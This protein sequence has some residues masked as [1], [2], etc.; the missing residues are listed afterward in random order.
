VTD[1]YPKI[2][3]GIPTK[4]DIDGIE[5]TV[6]SLDKQTI[7]PDRLIIC[8]GSDDATF[9]KLTDLLVDVNLSCDIVKQS[10]DGVASAYNQMLGMV[11]GDYEVFATLQTNLVVQNDWLENH[12]ECHRKMPDIG[13]VVP[14]DVESNRV[15]EAGAKGY[16]TMRNVSIKKDLLESVQ[17][18]DEN[19]LR[20]EDWDFHI[21]MGCDEATTVVS[22]NVTHSWRGN[23]SDVDPAVTLSKFTRRPTSITFI[24]KYGLWYLKFHPGHVIHDVLASVYGLCLFLGLSGYFLSPI[25]ASPLLILPGYL[26]HFTGRGGVPGGEIPVSN[27]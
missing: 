2:V 22:P 24:A 17:G 26:H 1:S 23:R 5:A 10:G 11:R 25:H 3:V 27:S 20:G 12:V 13:A 8:D 9:H 19:F 7:Q 4:G 21:R 15:R 6:S 18:W 14:G 16:F